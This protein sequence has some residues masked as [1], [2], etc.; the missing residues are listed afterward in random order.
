MTPNTWGINGTSVH[1][2]P[3]PVGGGC[4]GGM[5]THEL[6]NVLVMGG[7]KFGS[8]TELKSPVGNIDILPTVLHLLDLPGPRGVDGRVLFEALAGGR[9]GEAGRQ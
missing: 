8:C 2:A 5:S 4:H 9:P 1:D 3:Y 7:S 6:H